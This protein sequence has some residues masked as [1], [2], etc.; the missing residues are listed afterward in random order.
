[1]TVRPTPFVFLLVCAALAA[2]AAAQVSAPTLV[3]EGEE[4]VPEERLAPA[5]ALEDGQPPA[6]SG[7]E[8][9]PPRADGA[10]ASAGSPAAAAA[11]PLP[12]P[13]PT[14]AAD[15]A[16]Q[17][18]P[19]STSWTVLMGHW[20]DRREALREQDPA[21]AARAEH[22]LFAAKRELGIRNLGALAASEVR[23]SAQALA[24]NLPDLALRHA[25]AAVALGP[26]HADAHLA[27]AR[28]RLAL[29]PFEA[30]AILGALRDAVAAAIREPHTLRAFQGDLAAAAFAAFFTASAAAIVLLFLR[31]ARLFFH[32]FHHLPLLSGSRSIQTGFLALVLLVMPAAFGLGPFAILATLVFTV[33]LYLSRAERVV[34][35]LALAGL[36]ALPAAT[37]AVARA[38]AWTGTPAETIFA[39][40]HGAL[41]DEDV[42]ELVALAEARPAPSAVS[43]ALGRWHK[44]RGALDEAVR[45]YE[46]AIAADPAAPELQ[47]NLGNVRFLQGDLEAAKASYLAASDRA[48]SD[49]RVAAAA[50]YDLSKLYLRASDMEKAAASRERAE[51][52]DAG[53][54]RE[55]GADDDFSANRYLVDVPVP[56]PKIRALAAG[57]GGPRELQEIVRSRLFG[58]L[59]REL[60]PAAPAGFLGILW[61]ALLFASRLRPSTA[62][63][64]CGR[65]ACVRCDGGAAELCGQCVNVFMKRGVVDARDRLLKE[66]EV[67]RHARVSRAAAR[68]LAVVAGGAGHL[69][70]G[71]AGRGFVVLLAIGFAGFLMWFWRGVTPPPQP[72]PYVLAGKVALALPVAAALWLWS[73]RDV[74]RRTR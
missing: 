59:P 18:V 46:K 40:E 31:R 2:P 52:E 58:P 62:C 53:F 57:D 41:P 5:A 48:G 39:L 16:R 28:A 44:R 11:L 68:V 60:F 61:M 56:A 7:A 24:A 63:E 32:D 64:R 23:T 6:P 19:V 49:L 38:I 36:V 70:L 15:L 20:A 45:W 12:P 8:V 22:A 55:Y 4:I 35:T 54:L 51:A 14:P 30:G 25:E 29:A 1:M 43:A 13:P 27:L 17:I 50:H 73:V 66:S 37:G 65:A 26:D 3:E 69:Q 47:V 71:A 9:T 10:D 67:V 34:A 21:R 33:W 74:F 72:S 42:A